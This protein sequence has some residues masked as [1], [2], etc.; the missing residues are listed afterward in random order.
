MKKLLR[1]FLTMVCL[2]GLLSAHATFRD[3]KLDLTGGNFF[4]DTEKTDNIAST[5]YKG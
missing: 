3:I 4:T 2:V 5:V 1:L